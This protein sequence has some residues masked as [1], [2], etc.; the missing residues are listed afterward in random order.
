MRY[1]DFDQPSRP[2]E[3]GSPYFAPCQVPDLETFGVPA[4][5]DPY[6]D[7]VPKSSSDEADDGATAD[8]G[9][10]PAAKRKC[11]EIGDAWGAQVAPR[12]SKQA[13]HGNS[14][15][16]DTDFGGEYRGVRDRPTKRRYT[17]PDRESSVERENRN[18]NRRRNR[19][20]DAE[21]KRRSSRY[22]RGEV[23]RNDRAVSNSPRSND[24]L[25]CC[26]KACGSSPMQ[27]EDEEVQTDAVEVE[28]CA[29]S[30]DSN[31]IQLLTFINDDLQKEYVRYG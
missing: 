6:A 16:A 22:F 28:P 24:V 21:D 12:A 15:Y 26:D 29:V 20:G 25:S 27:Y 8:S 30:T 4:V 11:K 13:Q 18:S 14:R 9:L 17:R 1:A 5:H 19:S 10:A 2:E 3:N 31:R 7:F 23:S